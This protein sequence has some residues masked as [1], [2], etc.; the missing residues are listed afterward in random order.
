MIFKKMLIPTLFLIILLSS[1][2]FLYNTSNS[3]FIWSSYVGSSDDFRISDF[4]GYISDNTNYIEVPDDID[5]ST[6][7]NLS[8][9]GKISFDDSDKNNSTIVSYRNENKEE[10]KIEV[11][12]TD[13]LSI[14][15]INTLFSSNIHYISA[16]GANLKGSKSEV[17]KDN[18]IFDGQESTLYKDIYYYPNIKNDHGFTVEL[19]PANIKT[20]IPN[21][22]TL[23]TNKEFLLLLNGI[24]L[25]KPIQVSFNKDVSL[26]I[27]GSSKMKIHVT[28]FKLKGVC[29]SFETAETTGKIALVQQGNT[30]E[31]PITIS[32]LRISGSKTNI[33]Q[34]SDVKNEVKLSGNREEISINNMSILPGILSWINQNSYVVITLILTIATIFGFFK[35]SA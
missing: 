22:I 16:N 3:D 13:I 1:I 19:H 29:S 2:Y 21:N 17:I 15:F 14:L 27:S 32:P 8:G 26:L 9:F 34:L 12:K 31:I 7:E 4:S 24:V 23:S 10:K 30:K 35:K 11:K 20:M 18:L 6:R 5:T 25:D 33:S 28:N